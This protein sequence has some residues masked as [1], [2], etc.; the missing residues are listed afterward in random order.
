MDPPAVTDN[1]AFACRRKWESVGKSL[2]L[3][4]SSRGFGS[5]GKILSDAIRKC[6]EALLRLE[7]VPR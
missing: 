2:L 4:S 1:E 3:Y 6:L 7:M 5:S